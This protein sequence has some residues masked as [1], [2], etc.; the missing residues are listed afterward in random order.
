V[1]F[2]INAAIMTWSAAAPPAN[3]EQLRDRWQA[4]HAVRSMLSVVAFGLLAGAGR[5]ESAA[6]IATESA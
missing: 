5:P 4:A 2:P 6:V 3:W 1:H